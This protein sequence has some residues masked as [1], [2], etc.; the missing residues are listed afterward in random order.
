MRNG[1]REECKRANVKRRLFNLASGLSL[2]LC[3]AVA[4]LN[5]RSRRTANSLSRYSRGLMIEAAIS[6]GLVCFR[7]YTTTLGYAYLTAPVWHVSETPLGGISQSSDIPNILGFGWNGARLT[8]PGETVTDTAVVIPLWSVT[9]VTGA[10]P[11]W[12]LF[13]LVRGDRRMRGG[14]CHHCGYNLSG[15]TSGTCP[16]CGTAVATKAHGEAAP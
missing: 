5:V 1:D 11:I 15:N 4:V 10:L 2:L 9:L 7:V 12:W 3:V 16:E 8:W 6:D 13:R 14:L